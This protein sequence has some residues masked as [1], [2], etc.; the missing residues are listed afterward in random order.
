M[1]DMP[2][3]LKRVADGSQ[4]PSRPVA[5]AP[6]DSDASTAAPQSQ[7][8]EF[9]QDEFSQ[10]NKLAEAGTHLYQEVSRAVEEEVHHFVAG[11]NRDDQA[12]KSDTA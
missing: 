4:D 7:I 10:Q 3:E 6:E 2:G 11:A 5:G 12:Q 1:A 8:D 9:S